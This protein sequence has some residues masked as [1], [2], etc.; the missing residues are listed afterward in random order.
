MNA[1]SE[2]NELKLIALDMHNKRC[3]IAIANVSGI[4]NGC[5]NSLCYGKHTIAHFELETT[6]KVAHL[7][8]VSV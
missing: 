4:C 7:Q 5:L 2:G 6:E 8:P 3:K 1:T